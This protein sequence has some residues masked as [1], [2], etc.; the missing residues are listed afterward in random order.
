MVNGLTLHLHWEAIEFTYSIKKKWRYTPSNNIISR[1]TYRVG[2]L[3]HWGR[4]SGRCMTIMVQNSS[5]K[6]S[7][8][9]TN[10]PKLATT[11]IPILHLQVKIKKL[12][13]WINIILFTFP[14]MKGTKT[15]RKIGLSVK[16]SGNLTLLMV[17]ISMQLVY[18]K[19]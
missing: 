2:D 14:F 10:I 9:S 12:S 1:S 8:S 5:Q 7:T 15:L 16:P 19:D 3:T 11:E 18:E 13:I 6:V 17:K 4:F